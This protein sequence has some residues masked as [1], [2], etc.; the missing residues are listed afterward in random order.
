MVVPAAANNTISQD[1]CIYNCDNLLFFAWQI[2]IASMCWPKNTI[3]MIKVAGLWR[4]EFLNLYHQSET[5][6]F[7]PQVT[8][9]WCTRITTC[10][11][12]HKSLF[13]WHWQIRWAKL[14]NNFYYPNSK[15]NHNWII[16]YIP[17]LQ[18]DI[19]HPFFIH[20]QNSLTTW[21]R[22][23]FLSHIH[24]VQLSQAT[25]ENLRGAKVLLVVQGL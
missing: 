6:I 9:R 11:T 2:P 21:L 16:L 23:A 18:L 22:I 19:L 14:T 8:N 5:M 1:L 24:P 15:N 13:Y 12:N 7:N 4:L 25:D 10:E 20:H 17:I 3:I